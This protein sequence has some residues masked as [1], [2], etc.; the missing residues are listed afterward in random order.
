MDSDL[1]IYLHNWW[2]YNNH[3]KYQKYFKEWYSNITDSQ[4]YYFTIEMNR[5]KDW[6][7]NKLNK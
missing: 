6:M 2:K 4:K 3:N 7:D 1:K 5:P